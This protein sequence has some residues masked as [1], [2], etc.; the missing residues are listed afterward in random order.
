MPPTAWKE[1]LID[2]VKF[3]VPAHLE[4]IKK[5]GSG[6]YATVASFHDPKGAK[7]AV[8]KIT[9]VF[10]DLIECKRILREVKVLRS[11]RHDNIIN[12]LDMYPPEH[13]DFDDI[14]IITDLMQ[15][16][17]H[18]VIYSKQVLND[19]H[20]QYFSYQ[21]L[22]G[23]LYLHSANVVHGYLKPA[24]MLV[25]KNC[26]LKISSFHLANGHG[27]DDDAL[28][29]DPVTTRWYRAPEVNLLVSEHMYNKSIDVWSVGCVLCELVGR[30]PI[31]A[32]KENDHLGQIKKMLEV[33]GTPTDDELT[34]LPPRSPA[35]NLLKKLPH[36]TKQSFK[37]ICPKATDAGIEAIE[38]MLAFNPT[39]RATVSDCLLL[40]YYETLHRPDDEPTSE[41][42]V[43][44][45]FNKIDPTKSNLQK[46]MYAECCKFHPEIAQRDGKAFDGAEP[47]AASAGG[48]GR[49]LTHLPRAADSEI[50]V[51]S[52]SSLLGDKVIFDIHDSD[53]TVRRYKE[54]CRAELKSKTLQELKFIRQKAEESMQ[55]GIMRYRAA[56]AANRRRIDDEDCGAQGRLEALDRQLR[57]SRLL[58][59]G[60]GRENL[61][62]MI[63]KLKGNHD[64]LQQ[65]Q[66]EQSAVWKLGKEEKE[67]LQQTLTKQIEGTRGRIDEMEMKVTVC[68]QVDGKY[69]PEIQKEQSYSVSR[70]LGELEQITPP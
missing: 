48:P 36:A 8:K 56:Y 34:W 5:V 54:Q 44:W 33:L 13:H 9:D 10:H 4:L 27:N 32:C 31:F 51:S 22:R 25:N 69:L 17:L 30:K 40:R 14:Y 65:I 57:H 67:S 70:C 18:R 41:I 68:E 29:T 37:A 3:K 42:Q 43:D 63:E 16:D 50:Q 19:E 24:N 58:L 52:S 60:E 28:L 53:E 66:K 59:D 35:R 23:L 55:T 11:L 46:L 26:D 62:Q 21:I 49:N 61:T 64:I 1:V 2:G 7:L 15:S 20:H 39:K 38:R 12:I 45:A 6:V 47:S